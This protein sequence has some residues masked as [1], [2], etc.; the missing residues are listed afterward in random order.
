MLGKRHAQSASPYENSIG[1]ARATRIGNLI[2]VS[3]TAP[4]TEDGS[5]AFP[6]S[7]YKQTKQ[8]F[9]I[10]KDAI[11]SVGGHLK[12]VIRTRILLRNIEDWPEAARAHGE[13]FSNIKPACT[14]MEISRFINDDWLVEIEADCY[15]GEEKESANPSS[16]VE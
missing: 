2:S 6:G 8:C 15:V 1:F 5:T 7:L 11:E 3:G 10:A 16:P 9:E 4:I 13:L 14:F 12:D